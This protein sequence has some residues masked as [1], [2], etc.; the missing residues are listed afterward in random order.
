MIE[1]TDMYEYELYH[2]GVKGQKWGVRRY[3][4]KDGSLTPAGKRR[5]KDDGTFKTNKEYRKEI[6]D[7]RFEARKKY[8]AKYGVDEAY[9]KADEALYRKAKK[10]GID[11]ADI[12]P[13]ES[14]RIYAKADSL[15][16]KRTNDVDAEMRSKYGSD[17][18]K[19]LRNE[20]TGDAVIVVGGL[21]VSGLVMYG[22]IKLPELAIKGVCKLGEKVVDIIL[23]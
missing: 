11:P 13:D 3:Q 10:L 16:Q 12:D 1:V 4:N 14:E 17:Y 9:E 5:I 6:S 7:A 22:M 19:F 20:Q 18:D 23:K 15:S 21:A 2:H 8:N